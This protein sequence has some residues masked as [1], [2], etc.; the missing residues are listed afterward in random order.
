MCPNLTE[1]VYFMT[2]GGKKGSVL[3]GKGGQGKGVNVRQW[4]AVKWRAN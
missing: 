4:Q 3:G 1:T 2:D